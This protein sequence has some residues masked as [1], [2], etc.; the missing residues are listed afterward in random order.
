MLFTVILGLLIT[1]SLL[2]SSVA[3]V[4]AADDDHDFMGPDFCGNC[5]IN[6]YN[7]WSKSAHANA[8]VDPVFQERWQSQGS[9]TACLECH[10]TGF[11]R[12][13]GEY[14]FEGVTCEECHGEAGTMDVK[15]ATEECS[16][17]HNLSPL[18]VF[19]E[20][21]EAE[22]GH[23]A[24]EC[25]E[26]HE[27]HR[28]ELVEEEPID[29]CAMCHDTTVQD[30][31]VGEHGDDSYDCLDCHMA[32]TLIEEDPRGTEISDHSFMPIAPTPDCT[33]CHEVDLN[34]HDAW[35]SGAENCLTCHDALYMTRL[36]LLNGTQ[37][38]I[39]ESSILCKQC[40]NDVYY[41]WELG[42]HSGQDG[43]EKLCTD[44]HNSMGPLVIGNHTLP[45]LEKREGNGIP[46]AVAM[47]TIFWLGAVAVMGGGAA[48][49]YFGINHKEE[50]N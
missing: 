32:R 42:I 38:A 3:V 40:H 6:D 18:P 17:C 16:D 12:E 25:A 30:Y 8:F 28:L 2:R 15:K 13:T 11:E 47:P 46:A 9:P 4:G 5:H 19:E 10:T 35:G 48:I 34:T 21:L 26:C 41:E 23:S 29:L 33:E 44:C 45:P 14:I 31:S 36:H 7:E 37:L 24:I 50:D 43:Q 27:V 20:W 1:V 22:H 39:S 49:A